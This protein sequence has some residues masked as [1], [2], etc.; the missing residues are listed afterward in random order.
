M[1]TSGRNVSLRMDEV[2]N[3]FVRTSRNC[4]KRGSTRDVWAIFN[5]IARGG[6]DGVW[7]ETYMVEGCN[8]SA[9][10]NNMP[11]F[12]LGNATTI[13]AANR[14]ISSATPIPTALTDYP[15]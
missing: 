12:G 10:I 7:H 14:L 2:S 8:T 9:S 6:A 15:E 13:V 4:S 5:P 1:V 3:S 11:R